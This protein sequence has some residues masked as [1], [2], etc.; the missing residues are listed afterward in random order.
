MPQEFMRFYGKV[1]RAREEADYE[2]LRKFSK[3]ETKEIIEKAEKFV[4]FIGE[5]LIRK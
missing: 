3:E 5:N 4:K 1:K 2:L